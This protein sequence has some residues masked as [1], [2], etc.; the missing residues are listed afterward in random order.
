[1][2]SRALRHLLGLLQ[3]GF[4]RAVFKAGFVQILDT[5]TYIL[6]DRP[7][8][9]RRAFT[10]AILFLS[11]A[12][13]SNLGVVTLH[14]GKVHRNFSARQVAGNGSSNLNSYDHHR[15]RCVHFEKSPRLAPS[16]D[17]FF[18]DR[19]Q[20]RLRPQHMFPRQSYPMA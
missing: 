11:A 3:R 19:P 4:E 20:Q 7:I 5:A 9:P 15:A 16:G 1:M 2:G 12:P 6:D 10:A 17:P 18:I 14:H 13:P 8:A